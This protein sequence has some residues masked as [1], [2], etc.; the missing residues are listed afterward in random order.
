META[1]APAPVLTPHADAHSP[2]LVATTTAVTPVQPASPST[3]TPDSLPLDSLD[4]SC[5]F[6][7]SLQ[8]PKMEQRQSEVRQLLRRSNLI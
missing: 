1:S 7:E 4:P 3:Q 8:S 2:D 5:R 6:F